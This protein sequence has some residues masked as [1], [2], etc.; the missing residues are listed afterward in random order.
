MCCT[1][2]KAAKLQGKEHGFE[3][4][5]ESVWELDGLFRRCLSTLFAGR[6]LE[7][8]EFTVIFY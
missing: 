8:F 6:L 5:K 2:G 3:D 1:K 4:C 7:A